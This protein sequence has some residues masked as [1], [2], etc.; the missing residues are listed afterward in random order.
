MNEHTMCLEQEAKKL[1]E[2]ITSN[3][4]HFSYTEFNILFANAMENQ[5]R[6]LQQSF[7]R[8]CI[9][10]LKHLNQCKEFGR[11]DGRNEASVEFAASIKE[12]LNKACLPLI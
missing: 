1:A 10:W 7:T 2:T 6:S 4:N 11:F 5:H 9:N 3:L 12:Q 8:L